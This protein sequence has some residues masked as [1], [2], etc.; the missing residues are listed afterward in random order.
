MSPKF[1][2]ITQSSL[3]R[4]SQFST[5][6]ILKIIASNRTHNSPH[7]PS[8]V[9]TLPENT[10]PTEQ[11]RFPLGSNFERSRML[12]P[13]DDRRTR[14]SSKFQVLT[15]VPVVH[16][17]EWSRAL[18]YMQF[19]V[20]SLDA[21]QLKR[22]L[23]FLAAF[24]HFTSSNSQ[25]EI[26]PETSVQCIHSLSRC[27]ILIKILS[28]LLNGMRTNIAVTCEMSLLWKNAK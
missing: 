4:Y 27:N 1:S 11:T 7:H 8:R 28:S 16:L 14:Y 18:Q 24:E 5:N 6:N 23:K 10:L 2:S 13:S 3:N 12:Q 22:C 25:L 17:R 20:C 21:C 9:A 15:D 19:L 26:L